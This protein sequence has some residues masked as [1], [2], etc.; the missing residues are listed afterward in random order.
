MF[1]K[2]GHVEEKRNGGPQSWAARRAVE[3]EPRRRTRS[4]RPH[5]R[6]RVVL[7]TGAGV[8]CNDALR[9]RR[10]EPQLVYVGGLCIVEPDRRIGRVADGHDSV[11]RR[12][13]FDRSAP[14]ATLGGR[15]LAPTR[16]GTRWRCIAY[17]RVFDVGA[18]RPLRG[19][20]FQS[21]GL[22]LS[23]GRRAL[24]VGSEDLAGHRRPKDDALGESRVV[25]PLV[26]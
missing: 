23:I 4:A 3:H 8:D 16:G 15:G 22:S 1:D 18:P 14:R 26:A 24:Y 2:V 12:S 11:R 13:P 20:R 25:I 7:E 5:T 17:A 9:R 19:F 6:R 21:R 10:I